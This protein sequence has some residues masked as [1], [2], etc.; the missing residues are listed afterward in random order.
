MHAKPLLPVVSVVK[1]EDK[2]EKL[3]GFIQS[4]LAQRDAQAESSGM[5]CL[6]VVAR[7]SNSP[8]ARAVTELSHALT[9]AGYS[10]NVV[11]SILEAEASVADWRVVGEAPSCLGELRFAR[12]PRL[13]D[14][15]EQMVLSAQQCWIGDAMRRDPST[16]DAFEVYAL[17]HAETVRL[18]TVSFDRLWAVS[19]PVKR[20]TT[21]PAAR[22]TTSAVAVD[23]KTAASAM[24]A[25]IA[26]DVPQ[27]VVSTLH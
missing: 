3:K 7:S 17:E 27:F 4:M 26:G 9:A 6:T 2:L 10:V 22:T 8:V 25:A 5:R 24:A 14:A 20:T 15:H 23:P 16:R 19:E 18:S 11:L 1:H 13:A 21:R 12:N